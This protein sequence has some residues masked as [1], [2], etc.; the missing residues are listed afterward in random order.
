MSELMPCPQCNEHIF[1]SSCACAHCGATL[2]VCR[3]TASKTA[4]AAMLGFALTGCI[5]GNQNVDY[6]SGLYVWDTGGP[7]DTDTDT[8]TETDVSSESES[9]SE[10]VATPTCSV[11]KED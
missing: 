9:K 4:A 11:S 2:R 7:A 8:D 3:T 6:G 10:D 5:N 1:V